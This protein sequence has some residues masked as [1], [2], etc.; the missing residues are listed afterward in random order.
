MFEFGR[1]MKRL[2]GAESRSVADESLLELLP[3][4]MLRA[5]ARAADVAAGRVSA[6]EPYADLVDASAAWREYA[7]RTGEPDALRKAAAQAEKAC[8]KAPR[9]S[10]P[11]DWARARLE[12]ALASLAGAELYGDVAL[13]DAAKDLVSSAAPAADGD[14]LLEGRLQAAHAR[15]VAQE[16]VATGD[17]DRALEAAALFDQAVHKL[18]GAAEG[19]DAPAPRLHAAVARIERAELLT[20][21]G[22]SWKERVLLEQAAADLGELVDGL[23]PAYEPVTWARA[24]EVRGAAL[25]ALGELLG[26]AELIAAGV[27]VLAQ[28]VEHVTPDHSPIDWAR[29]QHALALGL[30]A[31]GEACDNAE[32]FEQAGRAFDRAFD[33]VVGRSQLSLRAAIASNR[34]VLRAR[35]A[36]KSGDLPALAQAE[37][38][39]KAELAKSDA[40]ADPVGWAVLQV[41]LARVYEARAGLLGKFRER[42]AAAYALG[43]AFEV[44]AERGLKSLAEIAADG[45]ERVSAA[46]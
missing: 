6:R 23:D 31:L 40:R 39:F 38:A 41:N 33:A 3:P 42:E 21:F 7:R 15:A 44:F 25:V 24:E 32:A 30:Q 37:A 1:E 28:H 13:A 26:E 20:A 27:S 9:Q 35:R 10:R 16:A 45:L 4:Q 11:R 17:Y 34:A 8:L 12:Q 18:S 19:R 43:A 14:P 36:E 5:E 22:S 29:N 2:F 46:A